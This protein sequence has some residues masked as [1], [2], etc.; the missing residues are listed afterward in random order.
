MNTKI[1]VLQTIR[2]GK[3]GGGESHVLSLLSRLDLDTMRPVVISFTE[4]EMVDILREKGITTYVVPTTKPFNPLVIGKVFNII[5]KEGVQ[6]IHAHGTRAASNTLRAAKKAGVPIIYTVH[7]WSFH[8]GLSK[9]MYKLR[10]LSEKYITQRVDQTICVSH[11]NKELGERL[12]GLKNGKVIENGVDFLKFDHLIPPNGLR[13]KYNIPKE[14]FL[15]GYIVRMTKQKD[16]MT[17]LRAIDLIKRKELNIHFLLV[18]DG[19]LKPKMLDYIS[20]RNLTEIIHFQNFSQDVPNVLANI[21]AYVLPS[22]WEG[23]PIGALEAM[24]MEKTVIVSNAEANLE[25]VEN[26]V[27]GLVITRGDD[28]GLAEAIERVYHDAAIKQHLA[29]RGRHH[30]MNKYGLDVMA[31]KVEA[32]YLDLV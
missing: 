11:E 5:K 24:A 18:G 23:L 16:P 4:G 13:N 25:L 30:V 22:L 27:N 7:A 15:V 10:V 19:D 2:Q 1:T 31:D 28:L 32:T 14:A 20:D 8:P 17:L 12:I 9:W 6:L 26:E 3:I 21:D 29:E